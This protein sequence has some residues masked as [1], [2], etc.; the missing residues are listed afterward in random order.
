MERMFQVIERGLRLRI[1]QRLIVDPGFEPWMMCPSASDFYFKSESEPLMDEFVRAELLQCLYAHPDITLMRVDASSK[2]SP[3]RCSTKIEYVRLAVRAMHAYLNAKLEVNVKAV[4]VKGPRRVPKKYGRPR[5]SGNVGPRNQVDVLKLYQKQQDRDGDGKIDLRF[6]HSSDEEKD[7]DEEEGEGAKMI[8]IG[9]FGRRRKQ[10]Q[11]NPDFVDITTVDF[12]MPASDCDEK[13]E[14]TGEQAEKEKQMK[15]NSPSVARSVTSRKGRSGGKESGE[16]GGAKEENGENE[17]SE[18]DDGSDSAFVPEVGSLS[19]SES[20]EGEA[21]GEDDEES[22]KEEDNSGSEMASALD[23]SDG[24]ESDDGSGDLGHGHH[25]HT[26]FESV[27]V[28][29][30]AVPFVPEGCSGVSKNDCGTFAELPFDQQWLAPS[31]GLIC[32]R[33]LYCPD[34]LFTRASCLA[35]PWQHHAMLGTQLTGDM[36]YKPMEMLPAIAAVASVH[37]DS[38]SR[39][40]LIAEL[41][42]SAKI[43]KSSLDFLVMSLTSISVLQRIGPLGLSAPLRHCTF[44][45]QIPPRNLRIDRQVAALFAHSDL[46]DELGCSA[47]MLV[48]LIQFFV[49]AHPFRVRSRSFPHEIVK[50]CESDSVDN[51]LV[52]SEIARA[53]QSLIAARILVSSDGLFTSIRPDCPIDMIPVRLCGFL[54]ASTLL[55]RWEVQG[56]DPLP[57]V[58]QAPLWL[59]HRSLTRGVLMALE[60]F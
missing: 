26:E 46:N 31:R 44:G 43:T 15:Q 2:S 38:L 20:D 12:T 45:M 16:E 29:P 35:A 18:D 59:P 37:F 9:R 1:Q 40:E 13:S 30:A 49:A 55:A 47:H 14:E 6:V 10:V 25:F 39:N 51:A 50:L 22:R 23:G 21:E 19:S 52:R 11:R 33:L 34:P 60:K 4:Q 41:E 58:S 27:N 53:I 54:G 36:D 42:K 5:G 24:G 48:L 8:E 32:R 7:K 3:A 57:V 56:S 17:R 28:R